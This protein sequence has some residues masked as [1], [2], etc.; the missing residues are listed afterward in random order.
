MLTQRPHRLGLD[1][2][3]LRRCGHREHE[4]ARSRSQADAVVSGTKIYTIGLDDQS[5]N[6]GTLKALAAAGHGEYAQATAQDLAPLFDQLG[7]QISNEYLLQYKSLL[8][9]DKPVRRPGERQGSRQDPPTGYQTPALPVDDARPQPYNPSIGS[10]ILG[11]T[12]TMVLLALLG[13]AA[14]AFLVIVLLQPKRSGLP[15]RMAEFVSIRGL[16]KDKGEGAAATTRPRPSRT[17]GGH[18]SRRRSRSPRSRSSRS[19]SSPEPSPRP[20]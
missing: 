6:P 7:Q 20:C 15:A 11:S 18:G 8:G 13:A 10:R 2:A 16:Q 1:R 14:I 5:Y 4:D 9:P 3:P 17:T 19:G 12:I